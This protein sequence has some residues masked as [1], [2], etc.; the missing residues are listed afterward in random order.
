[1]PAVCSLPSL[2][3]GKVKEL[4]MEESDTGR[5]ALGIAWSFEDVPCTAYSVRGKPKWALV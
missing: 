4:L 1:M 3:L 2:L 5:A